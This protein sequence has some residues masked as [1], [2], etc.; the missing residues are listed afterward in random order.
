[1][2]VLWYLNVH[3]NKK[4]IYHSKYVSTL[5]VILGEALQ[6]LEMRNQTYVKHVFSTILIGLLFVAIHLAIV[7]VNISEVDLLWSKKRGQR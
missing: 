4:L 1:M 3:V 7:S 2:M 5:S 6:V